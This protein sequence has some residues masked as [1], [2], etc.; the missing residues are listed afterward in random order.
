MLAALGIIL[1][2]MF[3]LLYFLKFINKKFQPYT[4]DLIKI[5]SNKNIHPKKQITLLKISNTYLLIGSTDTQISLLHKFEEN[6]FKENN[7]EEILK[8][9]KE[10]IED[11]K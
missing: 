5:I 10:K 7:F 3:L 4:T 6:N 8:E 9:K 2:L 1:V 11:E